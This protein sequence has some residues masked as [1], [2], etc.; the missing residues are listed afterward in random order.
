MTARIE[1]NKERERI[2]KEDL[3]LNEIKARKLAEEKAELI[4]K[5]VATREAILGNK[6]QDE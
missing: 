2:I 3:A 6:E 1:I 4:L 5:L